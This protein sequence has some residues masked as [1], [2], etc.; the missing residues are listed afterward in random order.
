MVDLVWRNDH[1]VQKTILERT[2]KNSLNKIKT[3]P[4]ESAHSQKPEQP[5]IQVFRV[6]EDIYDI[7]VS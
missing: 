2:C 6:L 1:K 3:K 4:C 5:L 7:I